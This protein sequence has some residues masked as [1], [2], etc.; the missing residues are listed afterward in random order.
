M[1]IPQ[2]DTNLTRRRTL[3]GQFADL[4]DDLVWGGFEPGRRGS[5]V[6]NGAGGDAF[7]VAVKASHS[8]CVGMGVGGDL[9]EKEM[10]T[11]WV[12]KS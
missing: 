2:H 12:E 1:T 11:S 5:R 10:S 6:G 9:A 3:L 7:A 4:I 8:E